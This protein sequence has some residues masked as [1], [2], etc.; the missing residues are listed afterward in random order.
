MILLKLLLFFVLAYAVSWVA[1]SVFIF[2]L[3][4]RSEYTKDKDTLV[5]C[6]LISIWTGLY[7][8]IHFFESIKKRIW[9]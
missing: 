4:W 2:V 5:G 9:K 8:P 7:M 1:C 6:L 3:L